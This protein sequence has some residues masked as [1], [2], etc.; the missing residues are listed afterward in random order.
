MSITVLLTAQ[1][2][3]EMEKEFKDFIEKCLT[4]TRSYDGCIS[5]DIYEDANK[6]GN[7]V[8]YENWEN[9]NAYEAY[10]NWRVEQGVMDK[11]GAMLATAPDIKYYDRVDI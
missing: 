9:I 5:I 6:K 11:I 4:E 2:K 8:F 7:F 1:T 3:P 10:L